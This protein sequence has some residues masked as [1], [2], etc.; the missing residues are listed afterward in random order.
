MSQLRW[1]V[2]SV[3]VM[4]VVLAPPA[5]ADTAGDVLS[6]EARWL[7]AITDGDRQSVEAILAPEF[8]H[9]NSKG[10]LLDRSQEIAALARESFSMNPSEQLVD[11]AGDTA[12]VHGV[13]TIMQD[14]T[15]LARER[16]T[17]VFVLRDDVW[18]ALSAQETAMG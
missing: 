11:I 9:I 1:G 13:N 5:G 18:M 15:V 3:A 10:Q 16:F 17:D 12:V 4:I 7:R 6:Q 14:R 8:K 2:A